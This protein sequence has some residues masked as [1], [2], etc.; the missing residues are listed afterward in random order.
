MTACRFYSSC[1]LLLFAFAVLAGAGARVAGQT[2]EDY[3][4]ERARMVS[5]YLEKE[6]IK[7]PRV[8]QAMRR[9]PRHEFVPAYQRR[10][11]YEDSGLLI[12]YK[13]TITWPFVVAFM[14]EALD[15]QPTDRV[16]EIG[17]GTGYQA[18]VLSLL[19]DEVYSIEIIPSLSRSAE[20]R[21]KRLGYKNVRTKI[22]DGYLGWPEK[23]PFDK[24]IVTCSPEKIPQPLV[25]QL[26]EGGRM[27]LPL[28]NR[29][30]QAVTL[31]EKRKGRLDRRDLL[32]TVFVPM[33]GRSDKERT[34]KF[35][36]LRPQIRNGGFEERDEKG[37]VSDWYYQL[38]MKPI[39]RDA[40]E[41]HFCV[42][43]ENAEPGRRSHALQAMGVDGSRIGSLRLQLKFRA[44]K[45]TD[46]VEPFEKAGLQV[47]FH[48]FRRLMGDV[49]AVHCVGTSDWK[50]ATGTV[51]VP[52]EAREIVIRIGL[53]GATGS[54]WLD[55]ITLTPNR[56]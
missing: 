39:D 18:A 49:I 22:G 12:G 26:K 27:V 50:T 1:L 14:T 8:L 37:T 53:N 2:H 54:L 7:N 40:P 56:R 24:I 23:A 3:D 36:P 17:T 32:P 34:I 5:E 31:L 46:G 42:Q 38:Q 19:A 44:E 15:P 10:R 43:F 33:T 55:D 45:V 52:E 29:Y 41:G 4:R 13:Q 47:S 16:L 35:D 21:L 28:G 11:A 25:D 30:E 48:N 51:T 20:K 9:V 6:G